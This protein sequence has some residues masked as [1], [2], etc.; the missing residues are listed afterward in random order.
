MSEYS[1][2]L[3][4]GTENINVSSFGENIDAAREHFAIMCEQV[5]VGYSVYLCEECSMGGASLA[6]FTR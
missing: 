6:S 1:V 3:F 4:N 2:W 5:P